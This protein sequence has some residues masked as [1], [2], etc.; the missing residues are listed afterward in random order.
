MITVNSIS[1]GKTSSFIAKN[2]PANYNIFSLV[3]TNDKECI[4][5]DKK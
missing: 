3:R 1:G 4:Y 5:P 2:Y